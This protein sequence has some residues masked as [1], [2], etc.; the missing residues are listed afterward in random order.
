MSFSRYFTLSTDSPPETFVEAF[1]EGWWYTAKA[2]D[3]R[4]VSCLTDADI[5]KRMGLNRP[6][7]WQE[8]F[9][10]TQYISKSVGSGQITGDSLVRPA[11]SAM[12]DIV[13]DGD[14]LSTGDAASAFDPLSSQGIVKSLRSGI[15]A[16]YAVSDRLVKKSDNAMPRYNK[17]IKTEFA[18]Y[19]KLYK[20]HYANEPRWPESVFWQRRQK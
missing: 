13:C 19:L 10:R 18:A 7:R 2:G 20:K 17:F 8:I 16:G 15:F 12:S 4:M 3:L 1:D 14:W 11:N 9:A 6:H 5:G